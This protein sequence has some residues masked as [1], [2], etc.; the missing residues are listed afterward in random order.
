MTRSLGRDGA[1]LFSLTDAVSPGPG[2]PWV[3]TEVGPVLL[4]DWG[5]WPPHLQFTTHRYHELGTNRKF[6]TLRQV[7][8]AAK[9]RGYVL[10]RL[11]RHGRYA[12]FL[13]KRP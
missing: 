8:R 11:N 6:R 2:Q 9:G 5:H 1:G 4:V 3:P 13:W 10:H 7:K 12:P